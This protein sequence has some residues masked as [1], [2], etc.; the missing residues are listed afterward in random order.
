MVLLFLIKILVFCLLE[1]CNDYMKQITVTMSK[2]IFWKTASNY[3]SNAFLRN[4]LALLE[5]EIWRFSIL[6]LM[7]NTLYSYVLWL[8]LGDVPSSLHRV[9]FNFHAKTKI[10]TTLQKTATRLG[11]RNGNL[12]S[13]STTHCGRCR[14]TAGYLDAGSASRPPMKG[15]V[16][17]LMLQPTL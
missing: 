7:W 11:S 12:F 4:F 15:A 1:I 17:M 3:L 6:H 5:A 2:I 14:I 9:S 13:T 8:S 10:E 16:K